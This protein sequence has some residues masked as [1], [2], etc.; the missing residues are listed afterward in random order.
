MSSP[1]G[2]ETHTCECGHDWDDHDEGGKDCYGDCKCKK[3]QTRDSDI[4]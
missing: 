2:W 3:F 4:F 1:P